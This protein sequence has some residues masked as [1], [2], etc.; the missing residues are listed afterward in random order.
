MIVDLGMKACT[1]ECCTDKVRKSRGSR[2]GKARDSS[3]VIKNT[4]PG[5]DHL[6]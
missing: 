3:A 1:H 4:A 5:I 2:I 6:T